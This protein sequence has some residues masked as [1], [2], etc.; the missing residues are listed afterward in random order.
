M[1]SATY[2]LF[3]EAILGRKQVV[4]VYLGKR[5]EVCPLVLGYKNGE[6]K[7]LTFQV[8]GESTSTLPPGGQWRCLELKKVRKA[9]VKDGPWRE[10]DQHSRPQACI[11]IVDLDINI[12]ATLRRG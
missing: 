11:D 4:C 1:A 3:R 8:G 5:R 7:C 10:G 2:S 6:E 12:A 9:E